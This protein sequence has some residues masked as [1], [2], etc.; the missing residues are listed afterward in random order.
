MQAKPTVDDFG[1]FAPSGYH[2]GDGY[3]R[4]FGG[5]WAPEPESV[6]EATTAV[7]HDVLVAPD[8]GVTV[9]LNGTE[10][11]ELHS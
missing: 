2:L 3:V 1:Q 7:T 11:G 6:F 8:G 10:I 5:F 4:V 9:Q